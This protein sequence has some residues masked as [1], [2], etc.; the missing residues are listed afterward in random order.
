MV[1]VKVYHE[2]IAV[3]APPQAGLL[4]EAYNVCP[5]YKVLSY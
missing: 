1:G 3:I 5:D 2:Y 4:V